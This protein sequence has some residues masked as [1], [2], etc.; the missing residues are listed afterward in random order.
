MSNAP[1]TSDR[2][3]A[4]ARAL[5]DVESY[6][7]LLG[8]YEYTVLSITPLG[9]SGTPTASGLPPMQNAPLAGMVGPTTIATLEGSNVLV[10]FI[11]GDP[12]RPFVLGFGITQTMLL[13][14]GTLGG[15][16]P[17]PVT[18]VTPIFAPL[19]TEIPG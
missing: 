5:I 10:V 13:D 17:G 8:V 16:A 18:V 14:A 12:S 3:L 15:S 11:N 9:M 2:A 19:V 6:G 7:T 4:P 1:A